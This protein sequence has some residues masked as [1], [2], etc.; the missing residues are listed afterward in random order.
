MYTL[1]REDCNRLRRILEGITDE[2]DTLFLT[3][4]NI[5]YTYDLK[6]KISMRLATLVDYRD[7]NNLINDNLDILNVNVF[8]ISFIS[9][10]Y[11]SRTVMYTISNRNMNKEEMYIV[12]NLVMNYSVASNIRNYII[13][14]IIYISSHTNTAEIIE[15]TYRLGNTVLTLYKVYKAL[16]KYFPGTNDYYTKYQTLINGN[17]E[18]YLDI[19]TQYNNRD[20]IEELREVFPFEPNATNLHYFFFKAERG[21]S[22]EQCCKFNKNI[23]TF[24]NLTSYLDVDRMGEEMFS[25]YYERG[26][27]LR[28]LSNDIKLIPYLTEDIRINYSD[29]R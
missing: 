5:K 26:M 22:F 24:R 23:L 6:R 28:Q 13:P 3:C 10:I 11:L 18:Y 29:R 16:Y 27:T 19:F 1:T 15:V 14:E 17:R 7:I 21:Y 25:E 8:Y 12:N 20:T 9:R 2:F 4:N